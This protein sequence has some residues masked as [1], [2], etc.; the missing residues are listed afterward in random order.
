VSVQSEERLE[1]ELDQSARRL[2]SI[3]LS[4]QLLEVQLERAQADG[5]ALLEEAEIVRAEVARA[6]QAA[7]AAEATSPS[8]GALAAESTPVAASSLAGM[9]VDVA[10][11]DSFEPD[12]EPQVQGQEAVSTPSATPL[13][14]PRPLSEASRPPSEAGSSGATRASAGGAQMRPM[15]QPPARPQVSS[16]KPQP[17]RPW[18]PRS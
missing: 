6:R 11:E 4:K 10:A 17:A 16:T 3:V 2:E 8:G 5:Q 18:P 15:E 9:A 1:V 13:M 12:D 14:S 7:A